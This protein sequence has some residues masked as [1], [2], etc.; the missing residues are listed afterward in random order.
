MG[1]GIRVN[2][3]DQ[4]ASSEARDFDAL[5]TG[6]YHVIITDGSLEE[7]GESSKNAGKPFWNLE[8]TVQDGPYEGRLL[9]T[10]VMLFDGALYSL[11]QL[12]KA[13]DYGDINAGDF[14]VP[15]LEEIIGK[16][17][18]VGA[19]KQI[20]KYQM[21]KQGVDEKL[22]KTEV[23]NFRKW[24]GELSDAP[25]PTAAAAKKESSLLP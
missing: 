2:F 8:L 7:V 1:S 16:D 11:S 5:P 21:E 4:E 18:T 15:E 13:L 12:M 17:I 14:E 20:D 3:S 24:T 6:K 9:W 25:A 23:K 10:N 19:R 22:Y